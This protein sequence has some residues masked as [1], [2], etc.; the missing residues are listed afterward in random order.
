MAFKGPSSVGGVRNLG[1]VCDR[2]HHGLATHRSAL[3]K[4]GHHGQQT[5]LAL[6]EKFISLQEF[7]PVPHI[8]KEDMG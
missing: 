2:M 6:L 5:A 4:D 7:D 8:W 1:C 3:C